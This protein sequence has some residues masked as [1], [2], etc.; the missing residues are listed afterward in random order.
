MNDENSV[1]LNLLEAQPLSREMK[2]HILKN[3]FKV[4]EKNPISVEA[5]QNYVKNLISEDEKKSFLDTFPENKSYYS[6][7]PFLNPEEGYIQPG[8]GD[9]RGN[10]FR[11]EW[12]PNDEFLVDTSKNKSHDFKTYL[13]K[14]IKQK[15]IMLCYNSDDGDPVEV[16]LNFDRDLEKIMAKEKI[17][18]TEARAWGPKKFLLEKKVT[19]KITIIKGPVEFKLF[20]NNPDEKSKC[21]WILYDKVIGES[22][23]SVSIEIDIPKQK[24]RW[25]LT[26]KAGKNSDGSFPDDIEF[27]ID[28]NEDLDPDNLN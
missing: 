19:L 17:F 15:S 16:P 25:V 10:K 7:D 18:W 4:D 6:I 8:G 28:D 12:P 22:K 26:T 20:R 9:T 23:K 2:Q 24:P 27:Y 13:Y 21:G 14:G 5:I 11:S 3:K 1:W